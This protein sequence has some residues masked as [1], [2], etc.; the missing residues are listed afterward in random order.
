MGNIIEKYGDNVSTIYSNTLVQEA[1]E[2]IKK[3]HENTVKEQVELCLIPA[4]S[5]HEESRAKKVYEKML[6]YG[7]DDVYMDEVSNVIGIKK[8]TSSGP[9][10]VVSAH[11]DTVFSETEINLEVVNG[12]IHA[13]GIADDTRGVA[14]LLGIIRAFKEVPLKTI[15][16]I[17]FVANVC[18]EGLG[19]LKGVKHI[20]SND[21]NINGLITIDGTGVESIVYE[22]IGSY[23]YE[24]IYN[25]TGGHSFGDFGLPS[26]NHALGRAISEIADLET[27]EDPKTT[28]TVGVVEGGTSVNSISGKS[29][30]LIDLRS[31][32]KIELDLLENELIEILKKA[33]L[34]ENK[35]WNKE[36][37][38]TVE[39]NKIGSRPVGIQSPD[40]PVVQTAMA[41][42][43]ILGLEPKLLGPSSTDANYPISLGIPAIST[44]RGGKSGSIHTLK[45]WFDPKMAYLGPQKTLL[46]ILSLVGLDEI[47]KPML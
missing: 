43:S 9:R 26:T 8:G 37:M 36:E 32:S 34:K 19:D 31:N 15:G 28:F 4:P 13:P 14:E 6:D 3:D 21:S 1:L 12:V 42:M 35:R 47:T 46:N 41:S 33:A 27:K 2:F 38:I 40:S 39:I 17:V 22:G 7:L 29:S 16:E 5:H 18:E 20:F 30:M 45:E 11:L 25:G 10:L 44:G 24:V 23:R